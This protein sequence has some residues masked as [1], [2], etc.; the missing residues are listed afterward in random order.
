MYPKFDCRVVTNEANY[1]FHVFDEEN[2]TADHNAVKY[3]M[4]NYPDEKLIAGSSKT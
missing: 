4:T 3:V 2:E 1:Y